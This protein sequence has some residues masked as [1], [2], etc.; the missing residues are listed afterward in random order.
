MANLLMLYRLKHILQMPIQL[1]KIV[2]LQVT[3]SN[4]SPLYPV[5]RGS[6]GERTFWF[7]LFKRKHSAFLILGFQE[8]FVPTL[9]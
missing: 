2:I 6:V 8:T 1:L 4:R 5:K 3:A 9:F 7:C